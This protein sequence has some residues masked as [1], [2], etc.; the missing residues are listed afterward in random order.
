VRL[1]PLRVT[2]DPRKPTRAELAQQRRL[3]ARRARE[4]FGRAR[5][6]EAGFARNLRAVARHVGAIVRGFATPEGEI[7]NEP[8]VRR[9]LQAYSEVL[10][11][12]AEAVG[13][14]MLAE[15]DRRDAAAWSAASREIGQELRAEVLKAPTGAL[16]RERLAEQVDL[17]TSLPRG[18]AE[19]VH[20]L[21]IRALEGGERA[22]AVAKEILR[23]GKVTESRAM[24]IARTEVGRTATELTHARAK[25]IGSEAYIWRTAGDADVRDLHKKLDGKVI[26]W[27]DPPIA[28]EAGERA[29]AG[30]IYNC[31]CW[32]DP[33][34]PETIT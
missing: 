20:R 15:V 33:I 6:A 9:A 13:S 23:T 11:P 5:K 7:R 2:D 26:R 16:M 19:R 17:I 3:A 14:K 30:S 8:A 25:H 27:D 29:H 22:K 24:L 32:A 4:R 34:L 12:W 21:T 1:G 31:R 10:K 28:G 18:A